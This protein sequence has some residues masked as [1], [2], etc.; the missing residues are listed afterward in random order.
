MAYVHNWQVL[1]LRDLATFVSCDAYTRSQALQQ[2]VQEMARMVRAA[3]RR[4]LLSNALY[5]CTP[6]CNV[7][8]VMHW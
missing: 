4:I 1:V 5:Y 7:L 3:C 8:V 6:S 2:P